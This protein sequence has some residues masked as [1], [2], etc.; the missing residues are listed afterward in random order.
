MS[1]ILEI[2]T[3]QKQLLPLRH[4]RRRRD[5]RLCE[6]WWNMAAPDCLLVIWLIGLP[7]HITRFRFIC[8]IWSVPG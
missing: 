8:R 1:I 4:F 2:W 3:I 5:C 7:C 6:R